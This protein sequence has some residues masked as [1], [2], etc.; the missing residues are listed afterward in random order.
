MQKGYFDD[1]PVDKV[2]DCK[3][4]MREYFQT[5]QEGLLKQI[6]DKRAIDKD[7]EG[8]LHAAIKD[9]KTFYRP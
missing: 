9:F 6:V 2:R 8:A 7:L 4:K 5:R 3:A 1:V